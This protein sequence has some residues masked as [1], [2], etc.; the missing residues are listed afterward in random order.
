MKRSVAFKTLGCRLN[1][2]ETD[3][4]LTDFHKAGFEIVDYNAKADVYIINTCTV[5][6]QGDH[7]SK[8]YIN[9]AARKQDGSIVIVTGCMA[10]SQKEYLETRG[11]ITYV[12]ENPGKSQILS[13]IEAHFNGEMLHPGDLKQDLFHFTTA[14]KSF[15]TRSMIKIQDGCDNFCSYCI[16]PSVRGTAV[17]RPVNDI[18]RHINEVTALGFREI[19]LTGVNISRYEDAGVDFTG[20]IG[21]I[22]AL[23]GN[24]RVRISSVEPDGIRDGF[25]EL[26]D[27]KKLCPH[28]HLCL[29]SGSDRI[30]KNM[31]RSHSVKDF[32]KIVE[33]L[34][35]KVPL[36]NLTT[37]I[38]VG[39]PGE[40]DSDF[41]A[42][43][44]VVK[45]IGFS[46]V[47]T[48]KYSIRKGTRAEKM[49]DQVDEKIKKERSEVI[50]KLSEENQQNYYS[51]FIGRT[52][53]VLVEKVSRQGIAKGFGEH[54]LPIEFKTARTD[55][56]Y[57]EKIDIGTIH[58]TSGHF[59]LQGN[60]CNENH[61]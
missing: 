42:T 61:S 40:T 56:N 26:F 2:F 18:L 35:E 49:P 57:F 24:F 14:E 55:T 6:N 9:Q 33:K 4:L 22:L 37:D 47:H 21:K 25:M 31:K 17:S 59:V 48:F 1:Q 44:R 36:F 34:R 11:D 41:E 45:G 53:I 5:T 13:L 52:Q 8:T 46:H 7:K 43:C 15:H 12:I 58:A 19:I 27:S 23:P 54:Y 30:L 10:T 51:G 20:L 60:P 38:I 39:F 50:R 28:L 16:V 3:A 29:Q 32:L